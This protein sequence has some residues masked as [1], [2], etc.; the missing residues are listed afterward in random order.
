M[1]ILGVDPGLT[2]GYAFWDTESQVWLSVGELKTKPS[3]LE[4]SEILPFLQNYEGSKV[5]IVAIENY[6]QRPNFRSNNNNHHHFWTDQT[7]AKII[8]IFCMWSFLNN[9]IYDEQEPSI[10]P[11]GYKIAKMTYVPGKK[12]THIADAMAH[13]RYYEHK[14]GGRRIVIN[15][16]QI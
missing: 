8:G 13:A 9:S 6:I 5:N 3:S 16:S 12:G 7:T 4:E 2:T 10:K 15:K 1:I 14:I 11:V